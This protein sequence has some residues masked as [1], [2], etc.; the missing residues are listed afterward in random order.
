VIELG[1]GDAKQVFDR[2]IPGSD[3]VSLL[4]LGERLIEMTFANQSYAIVQCIILRDE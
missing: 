4:E 2:G 1:L 3:P